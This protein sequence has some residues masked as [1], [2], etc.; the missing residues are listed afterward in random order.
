MTKRILILLGGLCCMA[1]AT[2]QD[3][4]FFTDP[5]LLGPW[6]Q[7]TFDLGYVNQEAAHEGHD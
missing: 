1:S 5:S 4:S 2:A 6:D 3:E 7:G